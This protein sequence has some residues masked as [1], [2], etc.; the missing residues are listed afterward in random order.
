M[1]ILHRADS[2]FPWCS[3]CSDCN[4]QQSSRGNTS[5]SSSAPPRSWNA[6]TLAQSNLLPAK[7]CQQDTPGGGWESTVQVLAQIVRGEE[8]FSIR[9]LDQPFL[10]GRT[11]DG[12]CC[13]LDGEG[14]LPPCRATAQEGWRKGLH[15]E[16]QRGH[17]EPATATGE[18]KVNYYI[19]EV[20]QF[21]LQRWCD[22][23]DLKQ[24]CRRGCQSWV[25]STAPLLC[26]PRGRGL[27]QLRIV[28]AGTEVCQS[29]I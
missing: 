15:H 4:P 1:T 23:F 8:G 20:V 26:C 12:E 11:G 21:S 24:R 14:S 10:Q 2:P 7:T 19:E 3:H 22:R 27:W 9:A 25:T 28:T 17:L 29:Q 18:G 16:M 13:S 5:F 6:S